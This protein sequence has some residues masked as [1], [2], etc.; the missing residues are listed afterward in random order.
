MKQSSSCIVLDGPQSGMSVWGQRHLSVCADFM[1]S[2]FN[3]CAALRLE[4]AVVPT[5]AHRI[6][7]FTYMWVDAECFYGERWADLFTAA[8]PTIK[9]V[10]SR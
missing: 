7:I 1:F 3:N 5:E 9:T 10:L 4:V 2:Y 8:D 6:C